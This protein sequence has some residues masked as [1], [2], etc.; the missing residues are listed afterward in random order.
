MDENRPLLIILQS[1]NDFA[2][3][4]SFP[5]GTGLSNTLALRYHW[6]RVPVPGSQGAKVSEQELDTHTPGNDKYLVNFEV[7]P[8][9]AAAPPPGLRTTNNRAFEANV[10]QNIRG[11]TFYTSEKNDGHE[12]QFCRNSDYNPDEVRPPTGN[13]LWQRWEI[14]YTGNARVPCWIVR[15]PKEIIWG[16]G[17]I[18][19]DNSMAMFA[20]SI[21]SIFH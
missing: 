4:N 17:G 7:K 10:R 14:V 8:L 19:S 15:V 16:H 11:R 13:E 2:T 20:R 12:D 3:G 21:A 1:E 6:N 9:G 5:I 18:W